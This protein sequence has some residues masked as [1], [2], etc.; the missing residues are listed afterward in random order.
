MLFFTDDVVVA[1][2]QGAPLIEIAAVDPLRGV[3]FYTLEQSRGF[4]GRPGFVRE[5]RRCLQCHDSLNSL[6]VPGMLVRSVMPSPDGT[7]NPQ[8]GNHV[9]DH[10]SRLEDRWGGYYV[11]GRHPDVAHLGNGTVTDIRDETSIRDN[12][13]LTLDSITAHIDSGTTLTDTSDIVALMVF[14]HQMHMTNLLVRYGW[15]V[16]YAMAG[17][18]EG[19]ASGVDLSAAAREVVDYM[20]FV[21]EADLPGPIEG[22]SGFRRAFESRGP[23]D[24]RGRSLRQLDLDRR[25]MRYPL[26]YM[27]DSNAFDGMPVEARNALYFRLWQILSGRDAD[28]RYGRLSAADRGAILDILRETNP[29]L[30]AYFAAR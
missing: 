27:I 10:R 30:P 13:E 29:A 28:P 2:I 17:G 14:E 4:F 5:G 8:L 21:D 9:I 20:L 25:L 11:T 15:E 19:A 12:Q 26:S 3:V 1:G 22:G 18:E 7:A 23:F 6:G 24:S 16:R